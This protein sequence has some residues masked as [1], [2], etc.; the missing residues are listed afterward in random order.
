MKV[1]CLFFDFDLCTDTIEFELESSGEEEYFD[2]AIK[3][4][5]EIGLLRP[6]PQELANGLAL[7][8]DHV[9]TKF[10]RLLS[11][12]REKG[13]GAFY[14]AALRPKKYLDL[15]EDLEYEL[16][17]FNSQTALLLDANNIYTL[18]PR[19]ILDDRNM[20]KEIS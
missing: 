7:E 18:V 16:L 2:L 10:M 11:V 3:A 20:F 6:L 17:G 19:T 8:E 4:I 12:F 9:F 5:K 14:V 15:V 13:Y 1:R